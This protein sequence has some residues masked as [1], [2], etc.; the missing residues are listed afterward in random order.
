MLHQTI[1]LKDRFPFLGDNNCDPI[2]SV[3]V[4][5]NHFDKGRQDRIRPAILICPGGGYFFVSNR[6]AEPIALKFLSEGYNTFILTYSVHPN[7]FPTAIREVAAA[8]EVIYENAEAWLTDV[9]RIAIMGF[10]AGGHLACHYSNCYDIPEVREVFPES[11][12]VQAAVLSYPVITGDPAHRHKGSFV[13]LTGHDEP[14]EEDIEK[15][16]LNNRVSPNTPPTFL[17]HT[18]TDKTVPVMNTLLYAQALAMHDIPFALHIYPAGAHGLA[19][20]DGVTNDQLD[21]ATAHAHDWIDA[22]RK[23]LAITL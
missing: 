6:E 3:Y 16:S 10:S 23:W 20:V 11:K 15:F 9:S 18:R 22:A 4:P 17:W 12:P 1:H 21:P 19:T 8:M 14:T 2:L 13:Y 5:Q 7:R